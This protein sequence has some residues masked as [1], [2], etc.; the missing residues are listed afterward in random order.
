MEKTTHMK[1][2]GKLLLF[3]GLIGLCFAPAWAS[4]SVIEGNE[5]YYS[6]DSKL[7][8]G[9]HGVEL[10]TG[11]LLIKAERLEY[12][13]AKGTVTARNAVELKVKNNQVK[14]DALI[15]D[16]NKLTG[17]LI[18]YKSKPRMKR[19]LKISPWELS[20]LVKDD[21]WTKV[22]FNADPFVGKKITG[23]RM[24]LSPN[25]VAHIS[26]AKVL[27]DGKKGMPSLPLYNS[28]MGNFVYTAPQFRYSAAGPELS[29]PMVYMMGKNTLGVVRYRY[30]QWNQNTF[31]LENTYVPSSRG[32]MNIYFNNINNNKLTNG[33]VQYQ[34]TFSNDFKG[35]FS[36]AL[37]NDTSATIGGY[38]Y[39]RYKNSGF[40][41]QVR[42]QK[43]AH[44]DNM[45]WPNM[46]LSYNFGT[47]PLL[48]KLFTVSMD[49]GYGY[50]YVTGS[51][52]QNS[53]T[54]TRNLSGRITPPFFRIGRKANCSSSINAQR[55][56]QSDGQMT[57]S[58]FANMSLRRSILKGMDLGMG[59]NYSF[60][61]SAG[62]SVTSSMNLTNK[63]MGTL[64][65]SPVQGFG[66][67]FNSYYDPGSQKFTYL[68]T[69]LST[70]IKLFGL[71]KL[72]FNP[73]YD[74]ITRKTTLGYSVD[75]ITF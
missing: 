33:S 24:V 15:F 1:A 56:Y 8:Y 13:V 17:T 5:L 29:A 49:G 16:T 38:I 54:W 59:Y 64:T 68:S 62:G 11:P 40:N 52:G 70:N 22:T 75:A 20:P 27:Q 39:K 55:Y 69:N 2:W 53:T 73:T 51:N 26:S 58:L 60:Y 61:S 4:Y 47:Y 50:N 35:T 41:L 34:H 14:A 37:A 46:S 31:N 30:D 9:H 67:N 65:F 3:L 12:D 7:I 66:F 23:K 21:P 18:Y 63:Y 25:Q 10:E 6:P 57:T 36:G 32:S 19:E 72:N 42:G 71:I 44:T 45:V 74:F 28:P 43:N 48:K